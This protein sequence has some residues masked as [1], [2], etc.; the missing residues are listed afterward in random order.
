MYRITAYAI[1]VMFEMMHLQQ[2]ANQKNK[3]YVD[4]HST[5]RKNINCFIHV[6]N[7]VISLPIFLIA[8]KFLTNYLEK[9]DW[10]STTSKDLRDSKRKF[11]YPPN[12]VGAFQNRSQ[13]K[14][15]LTLF[16]GNLYKRSKV[17][18]LIETIYYSSKFNYSQLLMEHL[19]Y[20]TRILLLVI[21]LNY[22][23]KLAHNL[24]VAYHSNCSNS[25]IKR[26]HDTL[27]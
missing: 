20:T 9:Y 7:K 27:I 11:Y 1:F 22:N 10:I 15:S 13:E 16:H 3:I 18:L 2:V 25:L 23:A 14:I 6:H 5:T 4:Y 26:E 19:L 21:Y 17:L 24:T 12:F 8:L